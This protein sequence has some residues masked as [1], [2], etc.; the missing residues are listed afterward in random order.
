MRAWLHGVPVPPLTI[1]QLRELAK[2]IGK[3][4]EMYMYK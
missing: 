2:L 4:D 3:E 1:S